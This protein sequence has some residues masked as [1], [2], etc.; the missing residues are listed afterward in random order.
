[1]PA[2]ILA[3]IRLTVP[4][5]TPI[6][7]FKHYELGV[8]H[9]N[10]LPIQG[11]QIMWLLKQPMGITRPPLLRAFLWVFYLTCSPCTMLKS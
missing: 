4:S 10:L 1:M 3:S 8:A 9:A 5:F 11:G 6:I 2:R 7:N